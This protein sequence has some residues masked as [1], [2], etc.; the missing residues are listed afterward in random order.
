MNKKKLDI[1]LATLENKDLSHFERGFIFG[2]VMKMD[3][4]SVRE[5]L[6]EELRGEDILTPTGKIR[7][8]IEKILS[9]QVEIKERPTIS[10]S[11][12]GFKGSERIDGVLACETISTLADKIIALFLSGSQG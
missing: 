6:I 11:N 9:E 5:Q 4:D 1:I 7:Q 3:D 12:G 10:Y 2:M 8:R